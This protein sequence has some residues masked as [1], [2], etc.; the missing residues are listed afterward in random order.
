MLALQTTPRT[1]GRF[2]KRFVPWWN[3]AGTNTVREKRAGFSRLR[4]HR[5]DP[6]CLEAFRR[7]RAQASRIFKEAQ[8]ASWKAYVSSINVHTSLTD[9]FNKVISQ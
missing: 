2:T 5:G 8:R 1:S 9:V 4:R 3:A 7:C 6:Q